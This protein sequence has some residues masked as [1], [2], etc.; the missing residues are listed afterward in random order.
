M[1]E[2]VRD[3]SPGYYCCLGDWAKHGCEHDREQVF[4]GGG[5]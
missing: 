4:N 1:D 3:P 5:G 2:D